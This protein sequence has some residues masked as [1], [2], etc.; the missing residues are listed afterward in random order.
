MFS[1]KILFTGQVD[2][3]WPRPDQQPDLPEAQVRQSR[4]PR[5]PGGELHYPCPPTKYRLGKNVRFISYLSQLKRI[6]PKDQRLLWSW[7]TLTCCTD[8]HVIS[9]YGHVCTFVWSVWVWVIS[10]LSRP[11]MLVVNSNITWLSTSGVAF[12]L[13]NLQLLQH[14][15][16]NNTTVIFSNT[17]ATHAG[18]S[19]FLLN[20]HTLGSFYEQLKSGTCWPFTSRNTAKIKSLDRFYFPGCKSEFLISNSGQGLQS[21]FHPG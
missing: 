5:G 15:T 12:H 16:T 13:G 6:K 10:H 1:L 18:I 14:V 21:Q 7:P 19:C 20:Q 2:S 9:H 17:H 3:P 4:G 8:F 11:S